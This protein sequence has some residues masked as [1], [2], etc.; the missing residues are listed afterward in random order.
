MP[1]T[2]VS[3]QLAAHEAMIPMAKWSKDHW[4]TLAYIETVMVECACFQVGL[5]PRMRS[6]RHNFR[7]LHEDCQWPL[8]RGGTSGRATASMAIVMRPEHATALNDGERV[9]GHDDWGCVLDLA[10]EGLFTTPPE[11]I[12]PC[13]MLHF[14]P[15]GL[16]LASALRAHKAAGGNFRSC[17]PSA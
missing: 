10:A 3:Q 14:A 12:D 5:D 4:S 11:K 16:A 6:N 9:A 2:R 8:R 7:I 15:R 17:V 13:V 1:A